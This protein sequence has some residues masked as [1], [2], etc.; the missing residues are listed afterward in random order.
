M[1]LRLASIVGFILM[2]AGLAALLMLR[3]LLADSIVTGP[4]QI[5]GIALMVWA[6]VTF[7]KRSF[8]L[9]ANPTEGGL[10]TSGPYQFVRHPIYA[11]VVLFTMAGVITRLSPGS[12]VW[13]LVMIVGVALRVYA[14]ETLVTLRYPEYAE[15]AARTKRII[16]F[17]F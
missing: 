9:A 10:V 14:E 15:Y 12:I 16:P 6:R 11:S 17:I 2:V 3:S 7:R 13:S 4:F 5:A 8:H 1:N